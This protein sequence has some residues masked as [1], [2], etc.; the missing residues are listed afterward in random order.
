MGFLGE[1]FSKGGV[2]FGGALQKAENWASKGVQSLGSVIDKSTSTI[3][4]ATGILA[5]IASLGEPFLPQLSLASDLFLAIKDTSDMVNKWNRGGN[6]LDTLKAGATQLLTDE[7]T[8]NI[9][10]LSQ[11]NAGKD[12]I[13][14]SK[15]FLRKRFSDQELQLP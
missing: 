10:G 6:F 12:L 3:S 11:I 15:S 5:D 9:P 2:W 14:Q 7:M 8:S 4:F 13:K 1:T